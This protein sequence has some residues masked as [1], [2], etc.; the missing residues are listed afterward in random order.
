MKLEKEI[1]NKDFDNQ[2][3]KL[4][5]NI[6]YTNNWIS[7]LLQHELK[8]YKITMQQYNVMR[9]L[10]GQYPQPI[11]IN[12]IKD[13]MLDKMSDASRIVTRLVEKQLITREINDQ[14]TRARNILITNQGLKLLDKIELEKVMDNIITENITQKQAELLNGLLDDLRG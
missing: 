3:H 9:I 8:K 12:I 13:R 5:V 4:V 7:T 1:F 10:R 2:Y 11:T 14:D 6:I